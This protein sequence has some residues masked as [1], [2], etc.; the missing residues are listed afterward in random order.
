MNFDATLRTESALVAKRARELGLTQSIIATQLNASQ[1][2][3]SRILS[4]AS[5]RRSKLFDSVCKYVLSVGQ[6][7]S[8][9]AIAE[10]KE[11]NEALATVWD[12]TPEHAQALALVIR[13][14]GALHPSS[15]AIRNKTPAPKEIKVDDPC[16]RTITR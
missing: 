8:H 7:P 16:S 3:V 11:L 13:S 1:S 5:R 4:G 2:Q 12:G 15:S 9:E 6:V 14:L 10:S